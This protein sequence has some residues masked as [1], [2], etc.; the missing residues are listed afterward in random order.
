VCGNIVS[1]VPRSVEYLGLGYSSVPQRVRNTASRIP[2]TERQNALLFPH[3][4]APLLSPCL[5]DP[6]SPHAGAGVPIGLCA[7]G[8]QCGQLVRHAEHRVVAG[9]ELV[10]LGIELLAARR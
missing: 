6:S 10:P 2:C 9:V 1:R 7:G 5:F 8:Q 3:R 4:A